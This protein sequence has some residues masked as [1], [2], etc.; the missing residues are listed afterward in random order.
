MSTEDNKAF[1][2]RYLAALSGNAKPAA[3]VNEY[4]DDAKLR[5]HIAAMEA[6]FPGYDLAAEDLIAEE[7]RVV[8]RTTLRGTHRGAFMG[9]PA[10][11]RTVAAPAVLI[12][13][14]A[15]GKIVDSWFT[16]DMLG[17]LYQLGVLTAPA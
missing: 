2:R 11:G 5:Q 13:R 16:A 3:L 8:V 17:L 1:V 6:A 7:D 9:T 14:I 4:V 12:Y 10:T 15:E